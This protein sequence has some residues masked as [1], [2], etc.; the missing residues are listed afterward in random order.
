[1]LESVVI[2]PYNEFDAAN[3]ADLYNRFNYGPAAAGYP[4]SAEDLQRLLVECGMR[5]F[6]VAEFQDQHII[7]G[8]MGFF[9]LSGQKM[10]QSGEV[11]AGH[12]FIHP[13]FRNGRIP[14]QLFS[15]TIEI[16]VDQGVDTISTEVDPTDNS[17]LALYKRVGLYRT[18]ACPL[19]YDGY[20]ELRSY[21]PYVI[22]TLKQSLPNMTW[23]S[24]KAVNSWRYL[25]PTRNTRTT[26]Y[27]F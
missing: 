5:L 17:A 16:L 6:L 13:E 19:D 8:T 14:G 21:L 3:I 25:L 2:R 27:D 15:K 23:D 9:S 20:L 4:L 1:M 18:R 12:F 22:R 11:F 26:E 24:L 7:V 10:A